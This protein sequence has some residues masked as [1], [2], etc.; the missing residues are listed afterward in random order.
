M[1]DTP[2]LPSYRFQ[3]RPSLL[4]NP[5]LVLKEYADD[6]LLNEKTQATHK[7]SAGSSLGPAS[8]RGTLKAV[9]SKG[10][11]SIHLQ[12]G[13]TAVKFITYRFQKGSTISQKRDNPP[14]QIRKGR[15]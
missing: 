13:S 3:F 1:R 5:E 12:K 10:E 8:G 2:F 15:S 6:D 11:V 4:A 9:L 7:E 14:F